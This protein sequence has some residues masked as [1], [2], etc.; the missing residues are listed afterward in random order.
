MSALRSQPLSE[1]TTAM[2]AQE[3]AWNAGDIDGFMAHYWNDAGL[4]F[5]TKNGITQGFEEVLQ[6][7]QK[8][9]PEKATMGKLHFEIL[10]SQVLSDEVVLLTG[11]WR[12][13]GLKDEPRGY[14][15]LI[16]KRID[17]AWKI[18]YDHTS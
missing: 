12:L 17:G 18:T 13:T 5:V 15:T 8:A 4:K 6:R 7:Y 11:S 2:A 16:W 3:A 14:F 9:Y 10:E 1:I